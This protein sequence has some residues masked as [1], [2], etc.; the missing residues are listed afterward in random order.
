MLVSS[1]QNRVPKTRQSLIQNLRLPR[2]TAREY[3]AYS[4]DGVPLGGIGWREERSRS[5][6]KSGRQL[7]VSRAASRRTASRSAPGF[8]VQ[9]LGSA[10]YKALSAAS[11]FGVHGVGVQRRGSARYYKSSTGPRTSTLAHTRT[12]EHTREH[13]PAHTRL[14]AHTRPRGDPLPGLTRMVYP[15]YSTPRQILK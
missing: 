13:T 12:C 10:R 15:I 6:G 14:R 11:G 1:T 3:V 9:A 7:G 2:E 4:Y 5:P 8:G